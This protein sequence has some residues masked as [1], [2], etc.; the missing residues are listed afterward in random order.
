MP[1][2][3]H[4]RVETRKVYVSPRGTKLT[5]HSAYIAAAKVLIANRC[6]ALDAKAPEMEICRK[7]GPYQCRFHRR[8]TGPVEVDYGDYWTTVEGDIGMAHYCKVLPRLVRFLKFVDARA[9]REAR[10]G[11][12]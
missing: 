2:T 1:V 11:E 6:A 7:E 8:H 9:T 10:R 5:K 12:R 4:V 3:P